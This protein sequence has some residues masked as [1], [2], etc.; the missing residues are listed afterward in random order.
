MSKTKKNK[1]D[2]FELLSKIDEFDID[3]IN[4]LSDEDRKQASSYMLLRWMAC[5]NDRDKITRLA[6]MPNK[7]IFS[8]NKTPSL[9]MHLLSSCGSGKKEFYKWKKKEGR[10]QT[11]PVTTDLL[12]EYYNM[13]KDDATRDSELMNLDS[14]I[15]IAENLGRYDDISKLKK[16]FNV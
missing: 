3:Y 5:S 14:M 2:L 6:S 15:E 4:N 13:G 10:K 12:K 1:L 11:R 16:E 9:A 7:I 8:L